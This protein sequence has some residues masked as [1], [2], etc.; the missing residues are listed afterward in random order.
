M[1]NSRANGRVRVIKSAE[2]EYG[3]DKILCTVRD[4]SITGAALELSDLGTRIPATFNLQIPED[5]LV[6]PCSVVWRRGFR[7]G[8]QFL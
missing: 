8:V 3:G 7:M 1:V 4:L 6:L 2:I 5:R